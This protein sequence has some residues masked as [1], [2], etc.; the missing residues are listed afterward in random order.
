MQFSRPNAHPPLNP[1]KSASH[2]F[3]CPRNFESGFVRKK[4]LSPYRSK[5]DTQAKEGERHTRQTPAF[6]ATK[7]HAGT[8][9]LIQAGAIV[10]RPAGGT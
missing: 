2:L 9:D 8:R 4:L 6:G 3:V 7:G 10:L 1:N 5:T